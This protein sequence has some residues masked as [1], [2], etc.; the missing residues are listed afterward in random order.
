VIPHSYVLRHCVY[1]PNNTICLLKSHFYIN[2]HVTQSQLLVQIKLVY[3]AFVKYI[4]VAV[5]QLNIHIHTIYIYIHFTETGEEH[6]YV[7]L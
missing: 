6:I 4:S 7:D 1:L 5:Q 3:F 2:L